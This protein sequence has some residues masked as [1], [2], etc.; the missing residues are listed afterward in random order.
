MRACCDYMDWRG[1]VHV[2]LDSEIA[3][4]GLCIT[5]DYLLCCAGEMLGKSAA[6]AISPAAT[7]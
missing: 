6:Y 5:I 4:A 7:Q 3:K 1:R 2:R